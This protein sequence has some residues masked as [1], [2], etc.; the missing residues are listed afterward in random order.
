VSWS[1]RVE[2]EPGLHANESP[3]AMIAEPI[4]LGNP[5]LILGD[6]PEKERC[7]GLGESLG[8]RM[9]ESG[10]TMMQSVT[11]D[12]GARAIKQGVPS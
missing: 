6:T 5:H 8:I 1:V 3:T 10:T 12:M 4:H 2:S 9:P 11:V 7:R